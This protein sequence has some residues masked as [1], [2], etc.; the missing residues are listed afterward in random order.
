[1]QYDQCVEN[2]KNALEFFKNS[3]KDYS[4]K[5]QLEKEANKLLI[6]KNED[7]FKV[8]AELNEAL[9]K[10][11]DVREVEVQTDEIEIKKE[12]KDVIEID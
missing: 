10:K 11:L 6:I 3:I 12:Q 4:E 5:L 1:M 9:N 7:N 8:I 2:H